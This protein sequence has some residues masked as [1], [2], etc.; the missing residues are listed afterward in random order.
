MYRLDSVSA[1]LTLAE[2][3]PDDEID[4]ATRMLWSASGSRRRSS[5]VFDH[6]AIGTGKVVCN[7]SD[8]HT[9]KR[10]FIGACFIVAVHYIVETP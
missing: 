3:P 2:R 4:A 6:G 9:Y 10:P 1:G 5:K 8:V 7:G